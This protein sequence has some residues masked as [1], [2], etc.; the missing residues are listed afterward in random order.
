MHGQYATNSEREERQN[1][2]DHNT[3]HMIN[4]NTAAI[5]LL[6]LAKVLQ[7]LPR[8]VEWQIG[9]DDMKYPGNN[10]WLYT[11]H[12]GFVVF[13]KGNVL[14]EDGVMKTNLMPR[15]EILNPTNL[16]IE[17]ICTLFLIDASSDTPQF[18]PGFGRLP[19]SHLVKNK[20]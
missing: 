11:L 4:L 8:T 19:K 7:P 2:R 15:P 13:F 1:Q 14:N 3:N 18:W 6:V 5:L 10:T 9:K 16:L 20:I 12:I 17:V